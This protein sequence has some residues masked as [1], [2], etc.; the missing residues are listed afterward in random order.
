MNC[1]I[2]LFSVI[3]F[4]ISATQALAN[5]SPVSMPV[6]QAIYAAKEICEGPLLNKVQSYRSALNERLKRDVAAQQA[7]SQNAFDSLELQMKCR[8]QVKALQEKNALL[9]VKE[10]ELNRSVQDYQKRVADLAAATSENTLALNSNSSAEIEKRISELNVLFKDIEKLVGEFKS[11]EEN[12]GFIKEYLLQRRKFYESSQSLAAMGVPNQ[13]V[14]GLRESAIK[15]ANEVLS[16]AAS[17]AKKLIALSQRV[18]KQIS[19]LENTAKSLGIHSN[20]S[21][22]GAKGMGGP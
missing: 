14:A 16:E 19:E 17:Y 12:T 6:I 2:R 15:Q 5:V 20:A 1:F 21:G 3:L 13:T 11:E 7:I 22:K 10:L 8:V 18:K 9:A 4:A